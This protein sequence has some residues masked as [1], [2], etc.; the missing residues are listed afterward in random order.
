MHFG[1]GWAG[2][3]VGYGADSVDFRAAVSAVVTGGRG[4]G[5]EEHEVVLE[6]QETRTRHFG[7]SG[8]QP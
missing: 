1:D 3:V 7:T 2:P 4:D 6:V 8:Q 5:C